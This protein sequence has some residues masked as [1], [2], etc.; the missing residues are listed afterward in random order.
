VRQFAGRRKIADVSTRFRSDALVEEDA[1]FRP[2]WLKREIPEKSSAMEDIV[3]SW[4]ACS[5]KSHW[6]LELLRTVIRQNLV[7]M[8]IEGSADGMNP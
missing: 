4:K 8:F 3:G 5:L 6:C 1:V 7:L 2:I